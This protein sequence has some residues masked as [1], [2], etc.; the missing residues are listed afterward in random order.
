MASIQFVKVGGLITCDDDRV[1]LEGHYSPGDAG[2][3]SGPNMCPPEPAEFNVSRIVRDENGDDVDLPDEEI[4]RLEEE[5]LQAIEYE[6][7]STVWVTGLDKP[8]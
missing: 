1:I 3:F 5:A 2:V 4:Q 8:Y 6:H 7:R